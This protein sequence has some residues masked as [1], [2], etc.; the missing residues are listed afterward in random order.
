MKVLDDIYLMNY[1]VPC[2]GPFKNYGA[3]FHETWAVLVKSGI[4]RTPLYNVY[5]SQN[6]FVEH[7]TRPPTTEY[8]ICS[9][10]N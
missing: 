5:G 10:E 1:D 3:H 4:L 7:V 8:H 9:R 6:E 2:K